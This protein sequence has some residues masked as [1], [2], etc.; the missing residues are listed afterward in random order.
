MTVAL[1]T[2]A[3]LALAVDGAQRAVVLAASTPTSCGARRPCSPRPS[4]PST[5]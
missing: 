1:D 3:L 5:A 2:S 4:P